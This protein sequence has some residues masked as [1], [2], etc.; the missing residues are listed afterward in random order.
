ME[1]D[2][3]S[4]LGHF[5]VQAGFTQQDIANKIGMHRNTI[6]KWMNRTSRP[7]SRGQV[8]KAADELSLSK[9]ERKALI[10]SAGFSL[11]QWP[12]EIWTVPQ[13]RDMFFTGR[14]MMF[15]ALQESLKPGCTTALTQA[16]SGLGGIGKT[17]TAI[18]YAYRFHQDYEAV[19]WLQADSWEVLVS[20]CMQL[21]DV[22]ALPEQKE[23]DQMVEA[24]QRWLRK[25]RNWLL[26][27][28]NVENPQEI[29]PQFVPAGHQGCVL[30]TTRVHNVEPLAQTQ[31]LSTM[32]EAEGVL[33]LLRRTTKIAAKAGLEKAS[34]EQYKEAKQLWHL[35]DGLPLALDQAGAYIL[36][37]RCS[38]FAYQEQYNRQRA[39]FLLRRGKRFIGHEASVATT[40]SLSFERIKVLNV[41][42]ADILRI[43]SLLYSE[44]IPEE[45]FSEG[46]AML[47]LSLR[48]NE[49]LDEALGVL[50]DYSL[51]LRDSQEKLL[52]VHRLVQAV[53]QDEMDPTE[54]QRWIKR[55]ALAVNLVLPHVERDVDHTAW[56]QYRRLLPQTLVMSETIEQEQIVS[57]EA[58]ELLDKTANYLLDC[59]R[60][61]EAEPLLRRRQSILQQ[62][63]RSEHPL[64]AESLR[65]LANLYTNQG[66]FAEAEPLFQ[67]SLL[68]LEQQLEPKH[69]LVARLRND[70]ATLYIYQAKY[71]E[72]ERL[73]QS[74]LAIWEQQMGPEHPVVIRPLVNLAIIYSLQG[75]YSQAEPFY[76]RAVAIGEQ[77]LG[78]E[79]PGLANPLANWATLS[80]QQG[81][82]VEAE[83]RFQQ[84]LTIW[85][86][87]LGADHPTIASVLSNLA[88]I[89]GELEKYDECES[90]LRRAL[91]IW[92]Q[93]PG[94]KHPDMA[95]AYENLG[96][97]YHQ[98][99][100]KIVEA[101]PLYQQALL[102]RKQQLDPDHPEIAS[103]LD[104]LAELYYAQGKYEQAKAFYQQALDIC[105]RGPES[106]YPKT[107]EIQQH[108]LKVSKKLGEYEEE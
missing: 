40:F 18:E 44:S 23:S 27:L 97:L 93:Q 28:D 87:T 74:A 101:E 103:V 39:A 80:L 86:Q 95:T 31:I 70:F 7:T 77:Q 62:Q 91:A 5:L 13:Q 8:L 4:L 16:I 63:S 76:R 1:E 21:A 54:K 25:H 92:E 69:A 98:K 48:E 79:H 49:S 61:Q 24:V 52:S 58:G 42:A 75:H 107:K 47:E 106:R 85:R 55:V 45:I 51:I 72:A 20:A 104:N 99:L 65:S 90:L 66:K 94:P 22:L 6:V 81:N 68:I 78:P 14:E 33:F 71:T 67:Q 89:S 15:Q 57:E 50:Q 3:A 34:P 83:A 9:Q 41:I 73:C 102:I 17:H 53:L 37:T 84:A 19:L 26:I 43:C 12:T 108:M 64:M 96:F 100:G 38:F 2:F 105:E 30:V 36:E 46:A 10:Q 56:P 60:Y 11:E 88:I 82:Y 32:P 29:L 59:A 35:L